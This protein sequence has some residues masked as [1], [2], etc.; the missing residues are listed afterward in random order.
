[1]AILQDDCAGDGEAAWAWDTRE[2]ITRNEAR[3]VSRFE[4]YDRS[5]FRRRHSVIAA[6]GRMRQRLRPRIRATT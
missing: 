1:M 5:L 2:Q 4:E 6:L 3:V